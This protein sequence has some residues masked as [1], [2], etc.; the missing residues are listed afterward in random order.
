MTE[1]LHRHL[2]VPQITP[3]NA[4][5]GSKQELQWL[6]YVPWENN[7]IVWNC[8]F[9]SK[10][11]IYVIHQLCH[12]GWYEM[13]LHHCAE[14]VS[15]FSCVDMRQIN[16]TEGPARKREGERGS[17]IQ[18]SSRRDVLI[19]SMR[20]FPKLWQTD[21]LQRAHTETLTSKKGNKWTTAHEQIL[22]ALQIEHVHVYWCS[23]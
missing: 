3:I 21:R 1:N 17:S 2:F 12:W 22:K 8:L 9:I 10:Q 23:R 19:G 5:W 16:G 15:R 11:D 18:S 4:I 6:K 14:L 20:W 13:Q 7:A